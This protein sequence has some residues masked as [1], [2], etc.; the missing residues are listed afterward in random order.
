IL[1]AGSSIDTPLAIEAMTYYIAAYVLTTLAGFSV[2]S[3]LSNGNNETD[4]LGDYQGLFWLR[5][6]LASGLIVVLL[7]LAGIP[8]TMGFIGKFYVITAG[9]EGGLWLLLS[10]LIIGSGIG[11]YY[12]L[13]LVYFMLQSP[14]GEQNSMMSAR[15]PFGVQAVLAGLS[16]IV[17]VL[18][19]YPAP[20][21]DSLYNLASYF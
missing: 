11:L 17:L 8:L 14:P 13:R 10:L 6:W 7:S 21:M 5:P 1:V 15:L 9:V 3:A 4:R 19:A 12:Y 2:V 16:L 18:G 20:L